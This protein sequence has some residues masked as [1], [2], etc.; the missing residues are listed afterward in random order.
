MS[1]EPKREAPQDR[2]PER[3]PLWCLHCGTDCHLFI[4]SIAPPGSGSSTAVTVCYACTRCG[5]SYRHLAD[6]SQFA[7]ALNINAQ[8]QDVLVFSGQYIHC[9]Q[10]M[11]QTATGVLRLDG[12]VLEEN[13]S[14]K[15]KCVYLDIRVLECPCG[16]RLVLPD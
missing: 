2:E 12:R 10:S 9:G 14:G 16:F 6:V 11:Q 8:S 15:A 13:E 5:V 7:G 1:K 4:R 3:L